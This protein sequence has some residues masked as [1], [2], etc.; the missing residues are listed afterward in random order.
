MVLSHQKT[1]NVTADSRHLFNRFAHS[2]GPGEF[3]FTVRGEWLLILSWR[4]L[5]CLVLVCLVLSCFVLPVADWRSMPCLA[6]TGGRSVG[7]S[8][9]GSV[10]RSVCRSIVRGSVGRQGGRSIGRLVGRSIGRSAGR[11][12]VPRV[13]AA[14]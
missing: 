8:V 14:V 3:R 10:D 7:R 1:F 2:A 13:K 9:G 6:I 11:S 4:V 5:A 12:V